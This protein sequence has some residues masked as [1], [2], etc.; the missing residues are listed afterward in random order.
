MTYNRMAAIGVGDTVENGVVRIH[1]YM[2]TIK[3]MDLTFAGKRGKV[4]RRLTIFPNVR[5]PD[6]MEL[7]RN[8]STMIEDYDKYD[9]ILGILKDYLIDHPE[10]IV[11][12][13]SSERGV[14]VTP[15]GFKEI[16]LN[17]QHVQIEVS[18]K[19]FVIKDLDDKN[20][21]PTAIS[22]GPKGIPTLYRWVSDNQDKIRSMKYRD[23]LQSLKELGISYHDYLAVD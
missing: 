19:Q 2:D 18:Y 10:D 9:R 11:L 5:G 13:E 6:R 17:G 1:R 21:E 4:V 23:V 20:N 15:A 3:V 12:D 8:I 22:K 16:V 7:L 14:D